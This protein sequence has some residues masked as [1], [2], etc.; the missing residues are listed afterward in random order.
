MFVLVLGMAG[1]L[2]WLALELP[3]VHRTAVASPTHVG[4]GTP[5]LLVFV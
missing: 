2:A 4:S 3:G 1:E 5:H